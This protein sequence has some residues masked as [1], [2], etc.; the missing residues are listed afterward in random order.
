MIS[1]LIS[2]I[3]LLVLIFS[4]SIHI[5]KRK[6][7]DALWNEPFSDLLLRPPG[8]SCRA[9]IEALDEKI[10]DSI[11]YAV[12]YISLPLFSNPFQSSLIYQSTLSLIGVGAVIW[13]ILR[14]KKLGYERRC[15]LL[16]MR[17]E[18]YTAEYLYPLIA[19]GYRIYHDIQLETNNVDHLIVGPAGVVAIET[20]TRRKQKSDGAGK[21]KVSFDGKMLHYPHFADSHGVEQARK[22]A[23]QVAQWLTSATGEPIRVYPMLCLPGWFVSTTVKDTDLMVLSPKSMD[24]YISALERRNEN[25]LLPVTRIQQIAHQI[26]QK[27]KIKA[28]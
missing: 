4:C 22:Q 27:C 26:E 11:V 6:Q 24:A 7:Q 17:G 20:K 15:Y 9:R 8:E 13:G 5:R 16:G 3:P 12:T 19:K 1:L 2:F 28:P 10:T 25:A 18:L 14:I 21:A 23:R